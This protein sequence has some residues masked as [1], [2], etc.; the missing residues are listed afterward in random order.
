MMINNYDRVYSEFLDRVAELHNAHIAFKD[1]A[2]H[3]SS[4]RLKKAIAD[5][6]AHMFVYRGEVKQFRENYKQEQR[7]LW[8]S[9]KNNLR[10]AEEA[11]ARRKELREKRK[12]NEHTTRTTG[13]I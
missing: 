12:Q 2:I 5:L 9:H 8:A 4:L 6:E 1:K 11:K 7:E 10:A 13:S 3:E